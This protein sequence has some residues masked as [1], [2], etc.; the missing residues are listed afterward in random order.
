M[1]ALRTQVKRRERLV[2]DIQSANVDLVFCLLGSKPEA[3]LTAAEVQGQ[4]KAEGCTLTT[5]EVSAILTKGAADRRI[6]VAGGKYQSITPEVLQ[7]QLSG[8]APPKSPKGR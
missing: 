7:K 1:T 5:S 2:D 6:K 8:S 3:A 4:L